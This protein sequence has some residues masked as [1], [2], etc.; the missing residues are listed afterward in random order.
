MIKDVLDLL[1]D[2]MRSDLCLFLF[3]LL[4]SKMMSEVKP[5]SGKQS[6]R[7]MPPTDGF[8]QSERN[9]RWQRCSGPRSVQFVAACHSSCFAELKVCEGPNQQ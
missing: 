8:E 3:C 5:K 9:Q 2:W 4:R 6:K 7:S 1:I